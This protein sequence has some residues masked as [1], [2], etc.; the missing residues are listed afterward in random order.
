MTG[1]DLFFVLEGRVTLQN[2]IRMKTRRAAETG[3]ALVSLQ[4]LLLEAK[5]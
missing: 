1:Q 5:R 4:Q 3:E 2:A